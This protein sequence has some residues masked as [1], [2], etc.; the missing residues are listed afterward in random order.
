MTKR[1]RAARRGRAETVGRRGEP[2]PAKTDK[3]RSAQIR[4]MVVR[5]RGGEEP[6]GSGGYARAS[7]KRVLA[8]G[9]S[10][11]GRI[12]DGPGRRLS[13]ERSAPIVA[14][15]RSASALGAAQQERSTDMESV[16]DAGRPAAQLGQ[17]G[18]ASPFQAP[19]AARPK[20]RTVCPP[21]SA[22]ATTMAMA[23]W[24]RMSLL[25]YPETVIWSR[26]LPS[27][28]GQIRP[29]S[30]PTLVYRPRAA[31]PGGAASLYFK[32]FESLRSLRGTPPV[33]H[34][35]Q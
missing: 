26:L 19:Q 10:E 35:G 15:A 31:L 29:G 16:D 32:S 30:T 4:R 22:N 3:G 13:P 1:P 18:A 7:R 34:P 33:W 27:R 5:R 25:R 6:E 8:A 21:R 17:A 14:G 9:A 2:S 11:R 20:G 23:E 28:C 24:W 12:A